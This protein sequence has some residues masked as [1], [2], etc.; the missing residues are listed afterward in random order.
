MKRRSFLKQAAAGVAAGAGA[1]TAAAPA[2]AQSQPTI[3]WR[4]AASWPKSLDTIFGG[5]EHVARRVGEMT[6]GKFQIRAFAAGEI[7]PA[8]QVLVCVKAGAVALG[9]TAMY[10]YFGKDAAFALA[11]SVC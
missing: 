6:D 8:R 2:V 5:A 7:V 9:H 11:T 4:M 1:T 3:Q 10:Y